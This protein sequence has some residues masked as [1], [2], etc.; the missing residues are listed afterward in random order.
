MTTEV[1]LAVWIVTTA[2]TERTPANAF[3]AKFCVLVYR[4]LYS[5]WRLLRF[6][7]RF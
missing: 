6:F 2:T 5:E 1:R 4:K 7:S 3:N